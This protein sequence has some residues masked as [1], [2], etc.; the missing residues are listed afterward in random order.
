M[1]LSTIYPVQNL[2]TAYTCSHDYTCSHTPLT[3]LGDHFHAID[4]YLNA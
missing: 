3:Y 2:C 1:G 4:T